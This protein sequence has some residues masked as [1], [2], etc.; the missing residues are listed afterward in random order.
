[1]HGSRGTWPAFA[2][3][4]FLWSCSCRHG[5]GQSY[6]R[7]WHRASPD[8]KAD[9]TAARDT[10]EQAA[11]DERREATGHLGLG[12]AYFHLK[13]DGS[14]ETLASESVETQP[15]EPAAYSSW[16]RSPIARTTSS[17][18]PPTGKRPLL[19]IRTRRVSGAA[20]PYPARTHDEKDFNRDVTSHFL[21]QVR[22]TEK[23]EAGR[24]VLRALEDA[25]GEVGR[26][27]NYYP[28]AEIQVTV[29]EPAVP[30]SDLTDAPAGAAGS[31]TATI[32]L[33]IRH[34]SRNAGGLRRL[35]YHEY[36]HAVLRAMTRSIP[37]C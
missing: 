8:Q 35:L 34:P 14:A 3:V 24:I 1:M 2:I 22:G 19:S 4:L 23:I 12:M 13:D 18:R 31:S 30:G 27:L 20:R 25:Y 10:F 5:F 33:P 37:T 26:A 28:L 6:G 16:E 21:G 32:R 29:L 17:P 15:P 9:Y 7:A 36:T 11:P